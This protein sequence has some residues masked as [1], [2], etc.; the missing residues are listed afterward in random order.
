M[1]TEEAELPYPGDE[2]AFRVQGS[3][4]REAFHSSG[5]L[6]VADLERGLAIAGK[7]WG[8]FER[9]LDFGCG[10]GRIM[11]WLQPHSKDCELHGVDIDE[12]AIRWAQQNL[13]FARFAVNRAEPPLPYPDGHFDLVFNHSVFTHIDEE[14]Q[15]LWLAELRRVTRPGATL[16]LTVNGDHAFRAYEGS[17]QA[18]GV[19][20]A[21]LRRRLS[22]R[23]HVFLQDDSWLGSAL[24][25]AYSNAYHAPWYL[26]SHWTRYFEIKAYLPRGALFFQDL[27]VLERPEGE[28][29]EAPATPVH[30]PPTPAPAVAGPPSGAAIDE[31]ARLLTQGPDPASA[32]DRPAA[33][34]AVRTVVLRLIRHYAE[35]QK[36][37][38]WALVRAI[39]EATASQP[40]PAQIQTLREAITRQTERINRL[41]SELLE[42]LAERQGDPEG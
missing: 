35:H 37:V 26:F 13:P 39:Q 24:P 1:S 30:E 18:K 40:A 25:E 27:L 19:D 28:L 29:P 14:H 20:P 31:V 6:S 8:S 4:S 7:S 11:L 10:S 17:L 33:A 41:E 38:D 32:S 9:A 42:A 21:P 23:G 3:P 34:A 12:R 15:D 16:M 36:Q 2:L 22:E 5:R